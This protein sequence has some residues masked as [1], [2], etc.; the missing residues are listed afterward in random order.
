VNARLLQSKQNE[1]IESNRKQI[2]PAAT[3][4]E[5]QKQRAP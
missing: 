5:K 4:Y 2:T 1:N 3:D